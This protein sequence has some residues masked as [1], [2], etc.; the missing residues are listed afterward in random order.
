[1]MLEFEKT[2]EE[3][4]QRWLEQ[5]YD[6]KIFPDL[7]SRAL[8]SSGLVGNVELWEVAEWA[9]K[10]TYL[11]EQRDLPARFGDPPI[12]LFNAPRFHIDIYFWLEGTTSI[13]QHGFCGAFQVL[14]GS[15]IHSLFKFKTEKDLSSMARIG[16][17]ELQKCELL[18]IGAV[19]KIN[20]GEQY[21]HSLFHLEQPSATIVARTHSIPIDLPQFAYF[22]P[23]LAIDPFFEEPNTV[24]KTQILHAAFRS[25][26][27]NAEGLLVDLL[28]KS[29]LHTSFHLLTNLRPQL[30]RRDLEDVFGISEKGERFEK[31]L[32]VVA[33]T[34]SEHADV[35]KAVFENLHRLDQI[36]ELRRVVRDADHRFFL[37]LLLNVEGR[38]VMFS[39]IKQ[40]FPDEDPLEKALDWISELGNTKVLDDKFPNALGVEG[41]TDFDTAVLEELLHGKSDAEIKESLHTIA[42]A[43]EDFDERIAASLSRIRSAGVFYGL[44]Q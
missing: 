8:Q 29:D 1:M 13:H 41:Y 22:K 20:P 35:F 30:E 38:D 28:K 32:N 21:I 9:L 2:G 44:L 17:L 15:S 36:V 19:Q 10:E 39:L 12:T 14:H 34:H 25:N 4:E 33:E 11:P 26:Y 23:G 6:E 3:L 7:A 24:K 31:L 5:G 27:E 40:R 43:S 37:A 16:S 18:S 42:G